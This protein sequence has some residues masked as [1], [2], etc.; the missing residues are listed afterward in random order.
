MCPS[1][2]DLEAVDVSAERAA[3]DGVADVG[4][5]VTTPGG[6]DESPR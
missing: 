4:D 2:A 1:S 6:C 5:G 3:A